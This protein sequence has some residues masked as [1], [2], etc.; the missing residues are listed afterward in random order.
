MTV[1]G[2]EGKSN[3]NSKN[4][5]KDKRRS[6]GFDQDDKFLGELRGQEALVFSIGL[7]GMGHSAKLCGNRDKYPPTFGISICK[8]RS[9]GKNL[10]RAQR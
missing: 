2:V 7:P 6:F 4:N 9:V 10:L 8:W 5:G 1:F 3:C